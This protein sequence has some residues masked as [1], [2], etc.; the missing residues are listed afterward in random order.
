[1]DFSPKVGRLGDVSENDLM[2]GHSDDPFK[3]FTYSV[4]RLGMKKAKL[5]PTLNP[6]S[7]R[8][9]QTAYH[10]DLVGSE[11][12][13]SDLR[14]S[15]P[16]VTFQSKHVPRFAVQQAARGSAFP[17]ELRQ[18]ARQRL[19]DYKVPERI[20][21]LDVLP[22]GPSGKV[23]RRALKEMLLARVDAVKSTVT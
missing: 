14:A 23:Q 18:F 8:R 1:M 9:A 10:E 5:D 3:N 4:F 19:A 16:A 2:I 6:G 7:A 22:K 15:Q 12:G 13:I 17:K 11:V 21:Y 20:R